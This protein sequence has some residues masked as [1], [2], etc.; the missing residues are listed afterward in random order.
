MNVC[1]SLY[2]C[3]KVY[4]S[5]HS[6]VYS[7]L[8]VVGRMFIFFQCEQIIWTRQTGL[9]YSGVVSCSGELVGLRSESCL[10]VFACF[11][12]MRHQPKTTRLEGKKEGKKLSLKVL[13]PK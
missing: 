1:V 3:I 10:L 5:V 6:I 7:F 2:V 13:V 11:S 9:D 4:M 12:C 8:S